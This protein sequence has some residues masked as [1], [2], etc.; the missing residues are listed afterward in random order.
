MQPE[1][2]DDSFNFEHRGPVTMKGKKEP[3]QCWFLSDKGVQG[4][5]AI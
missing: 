2:Q 5:T 1:N 4:A 3:M